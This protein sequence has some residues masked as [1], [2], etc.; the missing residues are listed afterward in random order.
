MYDRMMMRFFDRTLGEEETGRLLRHVGECARCRAE[1]DRLS[2][3]LETLERAPMVEPPAGLD[4]AVMRAIRSLPAPAP[5]HPGMAP[6]F[7]AAGVLLAVAA[8]ITVQGAGVI[9]LALGAADTLNNIAAEA[10]K[11][12]LAVDFINGLFPGLAGSASRLLWNVV[13]AG[14]V[15]SLLV[16][17]RSA[18]AVVRKA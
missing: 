8:A 3:V 11:T 1:F 9:G 16:G 4:E 13:M 15:S 10:W 12:Q 6:V 7:A 18:V 17:L 2:A 5:A 14:A